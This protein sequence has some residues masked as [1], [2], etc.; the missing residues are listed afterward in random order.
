[1]LN[2]VKGHDSIKLGNFSQATISFSRK[3]QHNVVIQLV[4][5]A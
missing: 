1:M 2:L 5:R 4:I 3:T